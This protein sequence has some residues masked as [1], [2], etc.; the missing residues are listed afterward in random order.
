MHISLAQGTILT[1]LFDSANFSKFPNM[2][3]VSPTVE[4]TFTISKGFID[5]FSLSEYTHDE[6]YFACEQL[7][8]SNI[9]HFWPHAQ[10]SFLICHRVLSIECAFSVLQAVIRVSQ[11]LGSTKKPSTQ[12]S[13]ARGHGDNVLYMMLD[14]DPKAEKTGCFQVPLMWSCFFLAVYSRFFE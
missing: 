2:K 1:S 11:V 14:L 3:L 4:G 6:E 10:K 7:P 13:R 9:S 12:T 8:P 5:D